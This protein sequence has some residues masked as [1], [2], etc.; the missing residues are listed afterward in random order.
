ERDEVAARADELE[1]AAASGREQRLLLDPA[2]ETVGDD[3]VGERQLAQVA[4]QIVRRAAKTD[5]VAA[6][7]HEVDERRCS[8]PRECARLREVDGDATGVR[9][10]QALEL[11]SGLQI[12]SV[13][14]DADDAV[15][16][17][18]QL[19]PSRGPDAWTI[20]TSAR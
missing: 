10:D 14:A 15:A 16:R 1:E 19:V 9:L 7:V 12:E 20:P 2:A 4:L 11:E 13:A 3:D 8:R 5:R 18:L 6:R 17:L